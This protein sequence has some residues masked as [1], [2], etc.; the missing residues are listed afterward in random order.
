MVTAVTLALALAFEPAEADVM[1]RPPRPPKAALL[2]RGLWARVG[3]IAL[4][5]VAGT[6]GAFLWADGQ[7]LPLETAR[8]LA[9][10]V[11]VAGEAFYLLNCRR[12]TAPS[13]PFARHRPNRA[14]PVAIG[15]LVLL[16]LAFTYAQP[17]QH[18]FHTTPMPPWLWLIAL[19]FG[20]LVFLLVETE[21]AV[22][23]AIHRS[24]DRA[25]KRRAQAP[26]AT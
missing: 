20:V 21:K 10:N 24:L 9:I 25:R 23:R 6:L 7:G 14:V 12:L 4:V 2:D 19:A 5:L 15:L 17:L 13:P 11:L 3:F 22:Q 16:Q 26:T 1:R 8:T 18:V